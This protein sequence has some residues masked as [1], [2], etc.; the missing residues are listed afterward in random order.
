MKVDAAR[1]CLWV[2][3]AIDSPKPRIFK[4]EEVGKA[5]AF[6]YD[7]ETKQLLYKYRVNDTLA[8]FFND[9]VILANGEVYLT[10]SEAGTIYKIDQNKK[11]IEQWWKG[12]KFIYPNG[13]TVSSD[14]KYLFV[15]HWLGISRIALADTQGTL[16]P[17]RVKTVLSGIDGLY[18]YNNSL[19]GVQNG[20][21][22]HARIMKYELSKKFDAVVSETVLESGNPRFNIPTT[23][24]IVG[25]DFYFIANSQ[26]GNFDA[27]GKIFPPEKLE[28]VY[29]QK[30]E[31]AE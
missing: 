15:A 18:F 24:V 9:V 31:L 19:I 26:L 3:N 5:A 27:E 30:L 8:H 7:L 4:K 16:L 13:I 1:N 2:M 28:P 22:P 21:G 23:G 14:Q 12:E 20:I 11:L 10:D 25:D 17:S 6:Q 29:I